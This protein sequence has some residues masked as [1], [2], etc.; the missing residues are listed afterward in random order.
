VVQMDRHTEIVR[1]IGK[2]SVVVVSLYVLEL[3]RYAVR[4]PAIGNCLQIGGGEL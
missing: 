4:G 1:D 2:L 3:A